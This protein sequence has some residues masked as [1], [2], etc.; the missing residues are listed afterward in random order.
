MMGKGIK[1]DVTQLP[2]NRLIGLQAVAS[3]DRQTVGLP[4]GKQYTNHVGSVH[5]SALVAVAEAASG[6]YLSQVF[7]LPEGFIALVRRLEVKFRQAAHGAVT[8]QCHMG[9]DKISQFAMELSSRGRASVPVAVEVMDEGG[10]VVVR[11]TVQ[12]FISSRAGA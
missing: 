12:W 8:A 11:A 9:E 3:G 6:A 10:T 1:L 5:A 7:G 4:A 2:F